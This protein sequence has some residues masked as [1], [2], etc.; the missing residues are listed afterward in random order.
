MMN[1]LN[2]NDDQANRI[3]ADENVD[4]AITDLLN[5][6]ISQPE[7]ADDSITVSYEIGPLLRGKTHQGFKHAENKEQLG[8]WLGKIF[9]T[10]DD[11]LKRECDL[12]LKVARPSGERVWLI[13]MWGEGSAIFWLHSTRCGNMTDDEQN[14]EECIELFL[15]E[16]RVV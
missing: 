14:M 9:M 16:S 4:S 3:Y 8:E 5:E 12:S 10:W 15:N 11:L 1:K 7:A 13:C 6:D 2:L